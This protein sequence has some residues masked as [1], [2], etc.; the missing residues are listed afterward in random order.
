MFR[1][2]E[3]PAGVEV[4]RDGRQRRTAAIGP[5]G[6]PVN[7]AVPSPDGRWIAGGLSLGWRWV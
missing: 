1:G 5:F 7:L 2:V 4:K 6:V 3:V